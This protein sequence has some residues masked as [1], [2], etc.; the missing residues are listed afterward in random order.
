MEVAKRFVVEAEPVKKEVV[1]PLVPVK[2]WRVE[3]ARVSIPFWSMV[4]PDTWRLFAKRLVEV[5]FVV[6]ALPPV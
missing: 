6:V 2:F 4:R 1:V 5:A 3:D